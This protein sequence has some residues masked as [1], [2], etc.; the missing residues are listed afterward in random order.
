MGDT[1]CHRAH[2]RQQKGWWCLHPHDQWEM[3]PSLVSAL[4][5]CQS[6]PG[7]AP[8]K[9]ESGEAG[10]ALPPRLSPALRSGK[11]SP[12]VLET[13]PPVGSL[14]I[15]CENNTPIHDHRDSPKSGKSLCAMSSRVDIVFGKAPN[16]TK[17]HP[18]HPLG[19]VVAVM[20]W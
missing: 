13:V 5:R 15:R 3:A 19:H 18:C 7:K 16:W 4:L 11:A 17:K 2:S 8:L 20:R 1:P 9:P 14:V 6:R 12:V 10:G